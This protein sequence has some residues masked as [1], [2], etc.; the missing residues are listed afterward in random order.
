MLVVNETER[1]LMEQNDTELLKKQNFD[2]RKES[3][4][5]LLYFGQYFDVR[6]I[7]VPFC[8]NEI[9]PNFIIKGI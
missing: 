6:N 1:N 9:E 4:M 5:L 3:H 8:Q 7:V 2:F